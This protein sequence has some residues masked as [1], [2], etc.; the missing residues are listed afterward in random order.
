MTLVET[1]WLSLLLLRHR[2]LLSLKLFF[3]VM[4]LFEPSDV[5]KY[6]TVCSFVLD[7]PKFPLDFF[8]A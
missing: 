6:P 4:L 5:E 1:Q 8:P 2:D 7:C 3:L